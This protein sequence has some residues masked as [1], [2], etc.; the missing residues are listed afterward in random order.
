M[1]LLLLL[2]LRSPLAPR[3]RRLVLNEAE[4]ER[5]DVN[6]PGLRFKPFACG[7]GRGGKERRGNSTHLDSFVGG[8]IRH[9]YLGHVWQKRQGGVICL[10]Y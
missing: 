7:K 4:H 1:S 6:T 2:F 3:G 9:G 5:R 8:T 10:A